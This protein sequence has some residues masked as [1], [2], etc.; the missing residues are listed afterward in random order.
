MKATREK[1][2]R[3]SVV[4][5][6]ALACFASA[7]VVY[8]SK[9]AAPG[10]LQAVNLPT[11]EYPAGALAG[12]LG[13]PYFGGGA[14]APAFPA[15]GVA[16]DQNGPR[17]ITTDGAQI[18]EEPHERYPMPFAPAPPVPAPV[19]TAGPITGLT[20]DEAGALLYMCDTT[21]FQAFSAVYP[22]PPAGPVIAVP[23]PTS[24]ISGIAHDS[25]TGNLWLC[26]VQGCVYEM[27]AAGAAIAPWPRNCIAAGLR[28]IAVNSTNGPGAFLPPAC[29]T[30]VP[31]FHIVV[32]DGQNVYDGLA[33]GAIAVGGAANAY[34][35]AFGCDGQWS[36]GGA[37]WVGTGLLPVIRL[38]RPFYNGAGNVDLIL[39]G[40]PAGANVFMAYG[41]CSIGGVPC[42]VGA[43]R[44]TSG[45][46]PAV[47][48]AFG[49]AIMPLPIGAA[50]P[51]VQ[52]T[53]Q[54]VFYDP[55]QPCGWAMSD[56]FTLTV[57]LR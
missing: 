9:P 54:W 5:W 43:F 46:V 36:Y 3:T 47:T 33:G 45:A 44:V 27:T 24:Q 38:A 12:P 41:L 7:Q 34:G 11:A 26:D 20:V 32:T 50:P 39:E 51:G 13:I 14:A 19:L 23:A 35:M 37:P 16:I 1:L 48:D 15:G 30:Q 18:W 10:V 57:G 52:F 25:L 2:I 49:R 53:T 42:G 4:L 28:G 17:I 22:Y 31:G 29:S 8:V 56:A 55:A 40:A 21:S 6:A